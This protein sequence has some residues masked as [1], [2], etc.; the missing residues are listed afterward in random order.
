MPSYHPRL[1]DNGRYVA[2]KAGATSTAGAVVILQ[3][4]ST[5]GTNAVV[6]A[7][8]FGNS[9]DLDDNDGPEMNTGR[10]FHRI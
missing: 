6:N 5:T 9:V 4:D 2:F 7:N 3:Y 10:A 1:S 8:G